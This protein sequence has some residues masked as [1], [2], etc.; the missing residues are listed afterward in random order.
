MKKIITSASLAA[1]GVAGLQAQTFYAPAPELTQMELNKPWSVSVTLRGFYDDNYALAPKGLERDSFGFEVSPSVSYRVM[2]EQTYIGLS[3]TY[4]M[5]YFEDRRKNSIDQSHLFN[6]K[7]NHSFTDRLKLDL[8]DTLVLT[9][10]PTI[11][12]PVAGVGQVTVRSKQDVLLN[13]G[14]IAI[15]AQLTDLLGVEV[16]YGNVY[17]DYDQTGRGSYSALLDRIEHYPR[18]NLRWQAMPDTVA[19]V[20][21]Q[22]GEVNH[23]SNDPLNIVNPGAGALPPSLDPN[24]DGDIDPEIRDNRSHS[25]YAGVEHTFN[26]QLSAMGRVGAQYTDYQKLDRDEWSPFVEV[27]A[28]YSYAVGSIV[29][30]GLRHTRI[31]TDIALASID[32]T[33]DTSVTLDQESTIVYGQLV[34]RITP[35]LVGSLLGQYQHGT[36]QGGNADD[37]AE[38]LYLIGIDLTYN[39]NP[40]WAVSI[41]YNYDRLDS[42]LGT[43]REY[44]RNRVYIGARATF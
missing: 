19:F 24:Q 37:Q 34:H 14:D 4:S 6:A 23:T 30:L 22:Y 17:Y 25:I 20:G 44:D 27:S 26:Q 42:D 13:R 5:R 12:E 35:N 33:G 21:Y 2:L 38:D 39:I 28:T 9:D 29:Q 41:G 1:L 15:K 16:G 43:A 18:V 32:G 10:E 11:A 31:Q 40:H 8:S 36:F 3:Y 7:L